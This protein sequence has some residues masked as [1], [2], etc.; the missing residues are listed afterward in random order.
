MRGERRRSDRTAVEYVTTG[1]LLRRLREGL[2]GVTHVVVDEV[3]ERSVDTDL[4]LLWLK[5]RVA[6]GGAPKV[7][8]MSAT[9]ELGPLRAYFSD[10]GT[11]GAVDV[12]GR[13]PRAARTPGERSSFAFAPSGRGSEAEFDGRRRLSGSPWPS[14]TS[15]RCCGGLTCSRRR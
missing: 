10:A 8:L 11:V 6:A 4:V 15:R 12:P 1:L 3:H 9:I 7:V 14:P 5:R 2:G 13:T